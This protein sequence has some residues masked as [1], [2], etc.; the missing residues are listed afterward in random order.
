M[1][2]SRRINKGFAGDLLLK[3]NSTS[4]NWKIKQ[5]INTLS[6]E[7]QIKDNINNSIIKPKT[8]YNNST[9]NMNADLSQSNG[10]SSV[11]VRKI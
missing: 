2:T 10:D 11:F 1:R 3:T 6:D 4:V 8:S 7:Y 9:Y 5:I